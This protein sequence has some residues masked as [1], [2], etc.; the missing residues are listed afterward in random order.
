MVGVPWYSDNPNYASLLGSGITLDNGGGAN[1][2]AQFVSGFKN[3]IVLKG[4]MT[5]GKANGSQYNKVQFGYLYQNAVGILL[6]TDD[7][8]TNWVN[9]NTITGGRIAGETGLLAVKGA[10]Q[11]D[12]YNGNKFYNI[13]FEGLVNGIDT[14]FF[15]FNYIIS[16]R[17]EQVQN[18]IN[19]RGGWSSDNTIVAT[20][21][22][23]SVFVSGTGTDY[24]TA[25]RTVFFG[26]LLTNPGQV[27]SGEYSFADQDGRFI[28]VN[29]APSSTVNTESKSRVLSLTDLLHK[30]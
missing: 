22:K 15:K 4:S 3:G 14:S 26:K 1:V 11:T 19:F 29:M 18:G 2:V 25:P 5:D 21:L 16:P 28:S 23:E 24:R 20:A 30:P 7:T 10:Q 8:G 12:P 27:T 6:T 13:G 9:E 17:F